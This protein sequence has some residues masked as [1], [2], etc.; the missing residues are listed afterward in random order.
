M[1]SEYIKA[2]RP[3]SWTAKI[4][5]LLIPLL[6]IAAFVTFF[7]DIF[8][9]LLLCL[10]FALVL[11]PIVDFTQSNG[12]SR[13][14][15]ILI[16]YAMIGIIIY[17]AVTMVIPSIAEQSEELQQSYKEFQVSEK[18]KTVDKWVEKNIP[19]MKKGEISKEIET[20]FKSSITKF[21]DLISGVFAT[22]IF[23]IAIPV[24]TFFMLRDRQYLKKGIISLIPNRYFEMTINI[25]AKIE[26]QLS[27]FV[28]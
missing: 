9:L 18:I 19:Y 4:F 17:G 8:I 23:I 21:E 27:K 2:N 11:N 13:T 6:V 14:L 3:L 22:V 28:R 24:I 12:I 15:S 16:V 5:I 1:Q 26:Y 20:V 10:L 25:I 7:T